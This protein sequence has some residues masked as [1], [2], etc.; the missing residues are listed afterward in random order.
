M[1]EYTLLDLFLP[2][3]Y[4]RHVHIRKKRR[5]QLIE[6]KGFE[7]HSSQRRSKSASELKVKMAGETSNNAEVETPQVLHQ[8]RYKALLREEYEVGV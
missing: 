2:T 8:R 6:N 3:V 5:Q 7:M 1:R 4:I